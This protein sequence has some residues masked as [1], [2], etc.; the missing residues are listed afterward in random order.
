MPSAQLDFRARCGG[1]LPIFLH[2]MWKRA[3][4]KK[5]MQVSILTVR[6]R[7]AGVF[8]GLTLVFLFWGDNLFLHRGDRELLLRCGD[9]EANPGP[10]KETPVP[11]ASSSK[12][13]YRQTRLSSSQAH[14][15]RPSTEPK[16]PS[17]SD[18]METLS[19][20]QDLNTSM[21]SKLDDVRQEMA[22]L[23]RDH[24]AL[25]DLV[26]GLK[27][28]C[29]SLQKDNADL[30]E[31]NEQLEKRMENMERKTDDL[32]CRS[33]RNNIIIHGLHRPEG[34][35]AQDLEDVVRELFSDKLELSRD[36]P[37]DRLHR[38]S[39]KANS[40]VIGCCTSFRDKLLVMKA[41]G[42][43]RGSDVFIGEDFSLRVREIR[44]RLIP[45]LKKAKSDNKRATMVYDHLI[46]DG[47]KFSVDNADNLFQTK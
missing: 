12:P 14:S 41:K 30:K 23:R 10:D 16:Q 26:S 33:K 21:N 45:H 34:E 25:H 17:L 18:V 1:F 37:F 8:L 32:E 4:F 15:S 11:S 44:R 28:E 47:N 22:G 7:R 27:D 9:V 46:I 42:K 3:V 39:S 40:P 31:K 20:L 36:V 24:G 5:A 38:L 19:T 2:F 6:S 43:L 35:T 29:L 13:S